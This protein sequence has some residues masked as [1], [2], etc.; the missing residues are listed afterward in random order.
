MLNIESNRRP[1]FKELIEEEVVKESFL[2]AK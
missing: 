1:T 2:Y